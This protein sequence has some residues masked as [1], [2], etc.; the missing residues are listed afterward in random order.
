MPKFLKQ[1]TLTERPTD[2]T[3]WLRHHRQDLAGALLLLHT[4]FFCYTMLLKAQIQLQMYSMILGHVAFNREFQ[5]FRKWFGTCT[6]QCDILHSTVDNITLSSDAGEK[7]W[8]KIM[9]LRSGHVRREYIFL[10][11]KQWLQQWFRSVVPNLFGVMDPFDDLA[12]SCGPP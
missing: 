6:S 5:L 12:E 8:Q 9:W 11:M 10:S 3:D 4:Q 1:I 2:G 7:Q